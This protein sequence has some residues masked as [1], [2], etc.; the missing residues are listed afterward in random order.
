MEIQKKMESNLLKQGERLDDLQLGGLGLIQD[1]DKFCFGVDAVLLSD[2]AKVRQG[3]TVV[4]RGTGNG[5]IPVLLAGKKPRVKIE[6]PL[7]MYS[8][9]GGLRMENGYG[10]TGG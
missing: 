8:R 9:D 2:F 7:I 5:I 3:E 10:H 4:D 1:P 6:P